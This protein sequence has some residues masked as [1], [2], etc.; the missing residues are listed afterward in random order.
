M[1]VKTNNLKPK[2]TFSKDNM[3][4]KKKLQTYIS[5]KRKYII[6]L[7]KFLKK[8][9]KQKNMSKMNS[10]DLNSNSKKYLLNTLQ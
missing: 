3:G 4:I 5:S 8:V 10:L 1:S 2:I 7:Q 9:M 6:F